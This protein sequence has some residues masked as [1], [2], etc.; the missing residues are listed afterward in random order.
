MIQQQPYLEVQREREVRILSAFFGLD[1]AMPLRSIALH[2]AAPGQDGMPVVFSHQL[3]PDSLQAEYFLIE[4]KSGA[5]HRPFFATLRPADEE[6]ELRT[7]LLIGDLGD[8][9]RD[10]PVRLQITGP[11]RTRDGRSLAGLAIQITPLEAGP[12]L[13][14]AGWFRPAWRSEQARAVGNSESDCPA[15]RTQTIVYTTWSGGVRAIDGDEPGP[16]E[17]EGFLVRLRGGDGTIQK[18]HPIA[19]GDIG[20]RD[21]HLDLCLSAAGT[22]IAVDVAPDTLIDP[23]GD[24]NAAVTAQI[25]SYP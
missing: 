17:F 3:D 5:R 25:E 12:D 13:V 10:P 11:L 2:L 19:F 6:S 18:I 16:R 1:D 21:N 22:P 4:T 9:D 23:R 24:A 15:D 20:D 14:H 7:A 8:A